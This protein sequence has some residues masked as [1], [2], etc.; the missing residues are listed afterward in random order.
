[1]I[2]E[3][4]ATYLQLHFNTG[5]CKPKI[6]VTGFSHNS[7]SVPYMVIRPNY[8]V[9]L[10]IL[11]CFIFRNMLCLIKFGKVVGMQSH[12][13]L[14]KMACDTCNSH[15]LNK[16]VRLKLNRCCELNCTFSKRNQRIQ[17]LL[18]SNSKL[19]CNSFSILHDRNITIVRIIA[20]DMIY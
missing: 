5:P 15:S 14:V 9:C 3:C 12:C 7:M 17:K 6:C 10:T 18:F 4:V 19:L 13:I 11:T 1:M 8:F 20:P 16:T 2:L